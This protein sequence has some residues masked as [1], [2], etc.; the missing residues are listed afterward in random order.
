ML[1]SLF[2]FEQRTV[3]Y[4]KLWES[5]GPMASATRSGTVVTQESSLR[6]NAVFAAVNLISDSVSM[7]PRGTYTDRNGDRVPA[8]RPRWVNQPDVDGS[9]WQ[10]FIQK[11]LTSKMLSHGACIRILRS[12]VGDIVGLAVL[13]PK[14]VEPRRNADGPVTYAVD[15]G[16]YT[17][18][19]DEMIYDTELM[20]PGAVK[21][22]SRVDELR[23]TLGLAKA[24]EEF[25]ATF[26]GS[27]TSMAGVIEYPGELTTEQAG[28]LQDSVEKGHKGYRKAHR[29]GVLSG[30]AKWVKTSVD[31]DEAQMLGSREFALEEVCR[32]FKIPPAMLQSQK[33]GSV[34]Y[35]SRE[36]DALQFV[37]LT[38]LPYI[39]ALEAHL[40]RLLPPGIFLRLNVDGL[41]RA[42]LTDRYTA[43]SVGTQAGFLSVN[44]VRRSEDL[45]AVDGGDANRVTLANVDLHAA[46]A[47]EKQMKVA[48]AVQLINAGFSPEAAL[49]AVELPSIAHTGLPSV[50]LQQ[51]PGLA[52]A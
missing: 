23:E 52:G 12:D 29:P 5:G 50:Q 21:G 2:R 20:M 25:S 26:F 43:Y 39:T 30:G 33:P 27:G 22:T 45:P 11:W 46:G 36:Q 40:S 44:D 14:R 7:L 48:M 1:N 37:T 34:A 35:A 18:T 47:T 6:V 31:P 51:D 32:A 4:Q 38:L 3:T 41:L 15:G 13:D 9:T 42:S 24:L 28:R 49:A 16:A 8:A 19:A 10:T 17:L